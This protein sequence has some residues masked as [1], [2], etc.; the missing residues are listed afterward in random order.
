MNSKLN[1]SK[2]I[3]SLVANV[4]K[5]SETNLIGKLNNLIEDHIVQSNLKSDC[6]P[7]DILAMDIGENES[8]RILG[9]NYDTLY[10][11]WGCDFIDDKKLK[12]SIKQRALDLLDQ[13]QI[14][15]VGVNRSVIFICH[16]MGGLIVKQILVNLEEMAKT[17]NSYQSNFLANTKDIV[18]LSTPHLGSLVAKLTANFSYMTF[19]PRDIY[20]LSTNSEYLLELN[21][22]FLNLLDD[23]NSNLSNLKLTTLLES[24]DTY[25]GYFNS[26]LRI[27]NKESGD[28]GRGEFHLIKNKDH[29]NICKP[30]NRNDFMYK[31]ICNIIKNE[32]K[33]EKNICEK[34]KTNEI[35]SESTYVRELIH[36]NFKLNHLFI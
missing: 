11:L 4:G 9:I 20:E 23:P 10:T 30:D 21:K 2:L 35:L 12:F 3:K 16:S 25:I 8:I 29:L 33:N 24:N 19:P 22:K 31:K 1:Q 14:A 15:K 28:I 34:C 5:E 32:I 18:F 7:K 26:Y 6:F 27:V 17:K 36:K 13:F